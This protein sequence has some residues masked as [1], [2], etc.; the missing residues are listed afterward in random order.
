MRPETEKQPS[1]PLALG[2]SRAPGRNLGLGRESLIP[3]G[4]KLG[5]VSVSRSSQSNGCARFPAEQN[6]AS[7]GRANPSLIS[8]SS[9]SL[10]RRSGDSERPSDAGES[11]PEAPPK[12]FAGVRAHRWVNAPPSSGL[13]GASSRPFARKRRRAALAEISSP[14]RSRARPPADEQCSGSTRA[15]RRSTIRGS[16]AD[17]GTEEIRVNPTPPLF[18]FPFLF[19]FFLSSSTPATEKQPSPAL[20]PL[21]GGFS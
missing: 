19:F 14:M 21:K 20:M 18:F 15:T 4:L 2:A 9:L 1:G 16:A 12:P 6:R 13:S 8:I 11:V 5:L 3:P 7:A 17:G 10:A